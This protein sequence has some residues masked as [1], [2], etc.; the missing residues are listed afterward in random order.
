MKLMLLLILTFSFAACSTA[1]KNN[2]GVQTISSS[3][4]ESE[5]GLRSDKT[6]RY[7]GL[8]NTLEVGATLLSAAMLDNQLKYRAGLMQWDQTTFTEEQQKAFRDG[9][10]KSQVFLSFYTPE[11]K[12]DDLHKNKTLW[13]IFLDVNG[14]RVEGKAEKLS[15]P[16]AEIASFYPY[17]S[18]FATPYIVTFPI[19]H[20]DVASGRTQLTL[21]SS[22]DSATLNL[23]P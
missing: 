19:S 21:T 12:M 23:N 9:N 13:K 17:H 15:L 7:K 11:K 22:L 3:Q 18:R 4:Y 8:H 1:P 16:T 5:V 10:Q 2:F 6:K 14:R 20:S